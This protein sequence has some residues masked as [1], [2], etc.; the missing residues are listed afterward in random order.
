[1]GLGAV[2]QASH[3]GH[4]LES[5]CRSQGFFH[6]FLSVPVSSYSGGLLARQIARS[7]PFST[8]FFL[9]DP[10]TVLSPLPALV[11]YETVATFL[12][13]PAIV[14]SNKRFFAQDVD[15]KFGIFL[16]TSAAEEAVYNACPRID[17]LDCTTLSSNCF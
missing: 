17:S 13:P 3:P 14:A 8:R 6:P 12:P 16:S 15:D 1:M 11:A 7:L 9:P 10:P 4:G 5:L 2:S